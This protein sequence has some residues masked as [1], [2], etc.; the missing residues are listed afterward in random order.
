M[1]KIKVIFIISVF[2]LCKKIYSSGDTTVIIFTNY[3]FEKFKKSSPSEYICINDTLY[4]V[5]KKRV[6]K[7][8]YLKFQEN[9]KAVDNS[10]FKCCKILNKKI[11]VARTG[12][13]VIE[14]LYNDYIEY[15]HNGT[16][17]I[18][19]FYSTENAW[20]KINTWEYYNSTGILSKKI[21][22]DDKGK[23]IRTVRGVE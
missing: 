20:L 5:G 10:L 17:K 23:F 21:I 18:K 15:N 9:S 4:W 14:S 12:K 19:G 8:D 2:L 1:V 6:L 16:L 13:W 3:T 11:V 22:Y 7:L